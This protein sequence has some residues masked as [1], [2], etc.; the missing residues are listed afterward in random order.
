M[1]K[2]SFLPNFVWII[3]FAILLFTFNGSNSYAQKSVAANQEFVVS[4]LDS[5]GHYKITLT[6]TIDKDNNAMVSGIVANASPN[7]IHTVYIVGD[8]IHSTGSCMDTAEIEITGKRLGS[9]R[10]L[11]D[12]D[13]TAPK[14]VDDGGDVFKFYCYSEN[15]IK[16]SSSLPQLTTSGNET[17]VSCIQSCQVCVLKHFVTPSRIKEGGGVYIYANSVTYK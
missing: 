12:F 2:K 5:S 13:Q 4:S 3:G 17:Y 9:Q 14:V 1:N 8:S 11:V 10:F 15:C 16:N 6:I 7:D